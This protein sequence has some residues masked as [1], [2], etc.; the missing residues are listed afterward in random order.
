MSSFARNLADKLLK[1]PNG[2]PAKLLGPMSLAL[3]RE[4]PGT[5]P[6]YDPGE[7]TITDYPLHGVATG[8]SAYRADGTLVTTADKMVTVAV[9]DVEPLMTDKVLIEGKAHSIIKIERKTEAGEAAAFLIF[10]R[11]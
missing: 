5:G 4:I 2:L 1:G 10:V 11:A 3:R 9:P 7:P 6:A 8:V